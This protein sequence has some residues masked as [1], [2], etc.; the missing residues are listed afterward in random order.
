MG[1]GNLADYK[2]NRRSM[3]MMLINL[4]L[5]IIALVLG[6]VLLERKRTWSAIL[7]FFIGAGWFFNVIMFTVHFS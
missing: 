5:G 3:F 1:F 6:F 2:E 7:V 4:L